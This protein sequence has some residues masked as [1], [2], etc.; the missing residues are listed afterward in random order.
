MM[1]QHPF[2]LFFLQLFTL[3]TNLLLQ[4]YLEVYSIFYIKSNIFLN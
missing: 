1:F 2:M 4:Y 3:D